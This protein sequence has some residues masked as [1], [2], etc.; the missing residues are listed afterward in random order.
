VTARTLADALEVTQRTI[1]RD[2][3]ALQSMRIPIDGAAGIGYVLGT[4]C[5]LPPLTFSGEEIDAIVVGLS[6]LGRTGDRPLQIAASR[7]VRKISNALP[8]AAPIDM[9]ST[10]LRVSLWNS[11]PPSPIDLGIVRQA[12]RDER[13]LEVQYT[14]AASQLT[15]RTV[16]PIALVYYVDCVIL[17]A[18]CEL[19]QDF[20]HFRI[21]RFKACHTMAR[22]FKGEGTRLRAAWQAV[23][24][25]SI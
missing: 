21:D 6:L 23:H 7:V 24:L 9:E 13:K 18:W 22:G 8:G 10:P 4:R 14:D 20:R 19:R 1:Y 16:R 25:A 17:A 12:I 2:I 11:V 15:A 3:V 5:Y